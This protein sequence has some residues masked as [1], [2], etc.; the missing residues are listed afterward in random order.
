MERVI[1]SK[2]FLTFDHHYKK[3]QQPA[4]P[5]NIQVWHKDKKKQQH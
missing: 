1:M 2:K 5:M 3:P 4:A